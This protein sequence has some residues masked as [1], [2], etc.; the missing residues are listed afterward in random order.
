VPLEWGDVLEIPEKDHLVTDAPQALP[1]PTRELLAR[2]LKR[3]VI[4]RVHGESKAVEMAPN[5][6]GSGIPAQFSVRWALEGSGLLRAS[7]DTTRVKIIR[8]NARAGKT[9]E[10]VADCSNPANNFP[11]SGDPNPRLWLRDGDVI[12]VPEK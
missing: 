11:A 7:S 9:S 5:A 12:E 8:S 4:V 2:C 3:T 1:Q 6:T 10:W